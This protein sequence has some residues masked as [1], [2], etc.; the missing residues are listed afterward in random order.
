MFHGG[1]MRVLY[2]L[3][4]ILFIAPV[5]ALDF[6]PSCDE[7]KI[8]HTYY[9]LCFSGHHKISA[10]TAHRLTQEMV[11]G[12][13]KRTNKFRVDHAI[14]AGSAHP[15]D[16]THSGYDRGHLVP[17][18]DMKIS[19]KAM[20]DSFLMGNVTPQTPAFNRGIWRKLELHVQNWAQAE[21]ELY[22]ITGPVLDEQ[23]AHIGK[24]Q[25]SIPAAHYKIILKHNQTTVKAIA[26]LIPNEGSRAPLKSFVLPIRTLEILTGLNFFHQLPEQL[27]NQIETESLPELW[28]W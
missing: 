19:L 17:A 26:F 27:Q 23:P 18:G 24:T 11:N 7:E 5:F 10:W 6:H 2:F 4:C 20:T 28:S 14:A 9:S 22:I 12:E 21:K 1:S 16:Y 13:I 8:D 15:D 3:T 25:V